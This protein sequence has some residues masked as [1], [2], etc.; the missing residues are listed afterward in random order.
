M[1]SCSLKEV[2]EVI[3]VISSLEVIDIPSR[4]AVCQLP[5]HFSCHFPITL[6]FNHSW[7]NLS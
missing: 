4:F 3:E 1:P 6:L 5:P 7:K 2:N